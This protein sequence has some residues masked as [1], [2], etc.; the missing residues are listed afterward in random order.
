MLSSIWMIP[1]SDSKCGSERQVLFISTFK[2][3]NDIRSSSLEKLVRQFPSRNYLLQCLLVKY[4]RKLDHTVTWKI[5]QVCQKHACKHCTKK[6]ECQL[7][8]IRSRKPS[9]GR[10]VFGEG[11]RKGVRVTDWSATE[12]KSGK[13][14]Y[15]EGK[16]DNGLTLHQAQGKSRAL[17]L[18]SS[19]PNLL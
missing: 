17:P 14:R 12:A 2:P 15:N 13:L 6:T 19:L 9:E 3:S 11:R 16:R 5:Y 8:M 18:G 1:T 10:K 4:S 7:R